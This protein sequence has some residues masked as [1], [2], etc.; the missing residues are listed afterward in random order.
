MVC[1]KHYYDHFLD[2]QQFSNNLAEAYYDDFIK[3]ADCMSHQLA[4]GQQ[5]AKLV[6]MR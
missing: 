3:A 2:F 6:K 5:E 4:I 1:G